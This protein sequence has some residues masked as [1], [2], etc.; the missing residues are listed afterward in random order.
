MRSRFGSFILFRSETVSIHPKGNLDTPEEY[1]HGT[2][3]KKKKI[4]KNKRQNKTTMELPSMIQLLSGNSRRSC[5]W[6]WRRAVALWFSRSTNSHRRLFFIF[7][8][9]VFVQLFSDGLL[10][11]CPPSLSAPTRF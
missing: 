4:N 8:F 1:N 9:F 6:T 11:D 10:L 3:P 2:K 7:F 5:C